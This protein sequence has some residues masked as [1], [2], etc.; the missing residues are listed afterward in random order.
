M[1]RPV[2]VVPKM[3]PVT[4]SAPALGGKAASGADASLAVAFGHDVVTHAPA[5]STVQSVGTLL[6][7][8]SAKPAANEPTPPSGSWEKMTTPWPGGGPVSTP[9]PSAVASL[10]DP[11]G[12]LSLEPPL[13]LLHAT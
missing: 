1:L 6:A 13:E 2:P 11:S 5:S 8:V 7:A 10:L 4:V 9:P 3:P 12:A